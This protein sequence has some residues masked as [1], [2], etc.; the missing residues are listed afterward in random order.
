MSDK[1][2]LIERGSQGIFDPIIPDLRQWPIAKV[3]K[4]RAE[5]VKELT[6]SSLAQISEEVP[7]PDAFWELVAET[8]YAERYRMKNEPWKVDPKDE[9]DFW[10]KIKSRLKANRNH[11]KDSPE[12]ADMNE[13]LMRQVL[14]SY[15]EEVTGDFKIPTYR[16]AR[17]ITNLGFAPL[18]SA[19]NEGFFRGIFNPKKTLQ[20]KILLTGQL[21]MVREL[22]KKGTV[23][24]LPTH[25]S[26]LDSLLLGWGID[27]LGLPAFTYGAGINLF[28]HPVLSYFMT[29]LGA[30]RVDR[31]KKHRTYLTVLKHHA[32]MALENGCHM[33]FFPG[34]TR[35]RNGAIEAKLKLGLLGTAFEAQRNLILK[36]QADYKKIFVV[37]MVTSYHFV[38][39]ARN[40]IDQELKRSGQERYLLLKDDFASVFKSLNFIWKFFGSKSEVLMQYGKPMDL[41]GNPVNIEGESLDPFG[42][43]IDIAGYF[44][45]DGKVTADPQREAVFTRNLGKVILKSFLAENTVFSSHLVA[46]TAFQHF[47]S[48][49]KSLDIYELLRIPEEDMV[50]SMPAFRT[51]VSANLGRLRELAEKGKVRLADH[52]DQDLESVIEH[53]VRNLGVYHHKKPLYRDQQ[54]FLASQDLKLLLF[55][56]NRLKGYGL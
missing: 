15:A 7:D 16:F 40:L 47:K 21:E 42:R 8:Y 24:L 1:D 26:N 51:K 49:H 37:P 18:F 36:N 4:K 44:K 13:K 22:A 10:K 2:F 3:S 31:R 46:F 14:T 12:F 39:E 20:E 25:F 28:G 38:L 50:I 32:R 41:F 52:L 29:R 23:L 55:Y 9:G 5:M 6:E 48:A 11:A 53:G 56:H 45:S 17:K 35:S 43:P 54:G 33:L 19:A 30:Y 34:G 27:A